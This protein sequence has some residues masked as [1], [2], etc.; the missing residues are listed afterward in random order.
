MP[1]SLFLEMKNK[2]IT[3]HWFLLLLLPLLFISATKKKKYKSMPQP[4]GFV[5]IPS[6]A[7]N[8]H[9]V[10]AFWMSETEITNAQ[11][12]LFLND[13]IDS[14]YKE[15]YLLAYP[16]TAALKIK[17]WIGWYKINYFTHP[18]FSEC[19]V[20]HLTPK[21]AEIYCSW[22]TRKY[23][24]QYPT[25]DYPTFRIPSLQEWQYAARGGRWSGYF[26]WDGEYM[27]NSR[28]CLLAN[29]FNIDDKFIYFDSTFD[30][31]YQSE[32]YNNYYC[33]WNNGIEETN[34]LKTLHLLKKKKYVFYGLPLWADAYFPNDF[35]LYNMSGNAAEMVLVNDTARCVGGSYKKPGAYLR[36]DLLLDHHSKDKFPMEDVGFRVAVSYKRIN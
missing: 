16:D 29:F 18:Y 19:P 26:P 25:I 35:G 21:Q 10:S 7:L 30:N 1:L 12:H 34:N 9:S 36:L 27:R 23:R 5:Y 8:G 33:N 14:G 3:K 11:Y 20:V 6:G 28:G 31:R 13:L 15:Q 22:L 2:L 17:Q 4:Q 32:S 24:R